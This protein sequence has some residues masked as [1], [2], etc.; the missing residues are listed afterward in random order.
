[1]NRKHFLLFIIVLNDILEI[2]TKHYLPDYEFTTNGNRNHDP[3]QCLMNL[4][5]TKITSGETHSL[6]ESELMGAS[7]LLELYKSSV[8]VLIDLNYFDNSTRDLVKPF[9]YWRNNK[10]HAEIIDFHSA[11]TRQIPMQ[12][13]INMARIFND[14]DKSMSINKI[15]FGDLREKVN[16][17]LFWLSNNLDFFIYLLQLQGAVTNITDINAEFQTQPLRKDR[18]VYIIAETSN[19]LPLIIICQL[20]DIITENSIVDGY[21]TTKTSYVVQSIFSGRKYMTDE[22]YYLGKE[23]IVSDGFYGYQPYLGYNWHD[24]CSP[25]KMYKIAYEF[26]CLPNTKIKMPI[27]DIEKWIYHKSGFDQNISLPGKP[28]PWATYFHGTEEDAYDSQTIKHYQIEIFPKLKQSEILTKANNCPEYPIRP[29]NIKDNVHKFERMYANVTFD[30][31]TGQINDLSKEIQRSEIAL[32][33]SCLLNRTHVIIR[34]K[35]RALIDL[36]KLTIR[37]CLYRIYMG[38]FYGLVDL[39]TW[40]NSKRGIVKPFILIKAYKNCTEVIDPVTFRVLEIPKNSIQRIIYLSHNSYKTIKENNFNMKHLEDKVERDLKFLIEQSQFI[41]QYHLQNKKYLNE[42]KTKDYINIMGHYSSIQKF[43]YLNGGE[44]RENQIVEVEKESFELYGTPESHKQFKTY[45]VRNVKSGKRMK[46]LKSMTTPIG[47][48]HTDLLNYNIT[49]PDK[50]KLDLGFCAIRNTMEASM[51]L[52][53]YHTLINVP[54]SYI[55]RWYYSKSGKRKIVSTVNGEDWFTFEIKYAGLRRDPETEG[56]F[57]LVSYYELIPKRLGDK[58]IDALFSR[59]KTEKM[60]SIRCKN[61]AQG[62]PIK[63]EIKLYENEVNISFEMKIPQSMD[64]EDLITGYLVRSKVIDA[65]ENSSTVIPDKSKQI[66]KDSEAINCEG[67][68]KIETPK[69]KSEKHSDRFGILDNTTSTVLKEIKREI[70]N[71]SKT[72][73]PENVEANSH[74]G[75]V[76]KETKAY[77]P[78]KDVFSDQSFINNAAAFGLTF[79]RTGRAFKFNDFWEQFIRIEGPT[80]NT[81]SFDIFRKGLM[82]CCED[83]EEKLFGKFLTDHKDAGQNCKDMVQESYSSVVKQMESILTARYRQFE[84]VNLNRRKREIITA[85]LVTAG[86]SLAAGFFLGKNND[87]NE[88]RINDLGKEIAKTNQKTKLLEDAMI[89]LSHAN[90]ARFEELDGKIKYLANSTMQAFKNMQKH[91]DETISTI[92]WKLT[93]RSLMMD[94]SNLMFR[95]LDKLRN[96]LTLFLEDFRFWDQVFITLRR[97]LIP[98]ELFDSLTLNSMLESIEEKL[99]GDYVIAMERDDWVLFYNLPFITFIV[100]NEEVDGVMKNFLYLK[101]KIP[102]KRKTKQNQYLIVTPNNLP[103]PCLDNKCSLK[104]ITKNQLIAFKLPQLVWLLNGDSGTIDEEADLTHFSCQRTF[105][106]RLCFTY[107]PELLRTPTLCTKAIYQWNITRILQHCEFEQRHLEDYRV[108]KLNNYQYMLHSFVTDKYYLNCPNTESE[109]KTLSDWAQ[110]ISIRTSCDV[111]V[112]KTGQ[113]LYGPFSKP[114]NG[115]TNLINFSYYSPLIKNLTDKMRN[116]SGKIYEL[117]MITSENKTLQLDDLWKKLEERMNDETISDLTKVSLSISKKLA[118]DLHELGSNFETFTYRSTFWGFFAVIGDFLQVISTLIVIFGTLTYT[119]F[120]GLLGMGLVV[121]RP[122]Q[123]EAISI[124]PKIEILPTFSTHV[125]E[126]VTFISWMSKVILV[127]LFL[128]LLIINITTK[129]FRTAKMSIHYGS[130]NPTTVSQY[131]P[132]FT[133]EIN[134]FNETRFFSY[135]AVENIYIKVPI[136]K[137]PQEDVFD[138]KCKN[139]I[140]TWH[141]IEKNGRKYIVLSDTLHLV[142]INKAGTRVRNRNEPITIPLSKVNW[143]SSPEPAALRIVNNYDLAYINILREPTTNQATN[144]VRPSAPERMEEDSEGYILPGVSTT[145]L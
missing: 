104:N 73:I 107:S 53:C 101:L 141:V 118:N 13:V 58:N 132:K 78:R 69:N 41:R 126:D 50:S 2:K 75:I 138:I 76:F 55:N 143:T 47:L 133:I 95:E 18:F 137:M 145:L 142:A 65:I 44:N 68:T 24:K 83:M 48:E 25:S 36:S 35:L 139:C 127:M 96:L 59:A 113:T 64:Y 111:F 16:K 109:T 115:S 116:L 93:L 61:M 66:E 144:A 102:L 77:K 92:E 26:L 11:T 52:S 70:N 88:E 89:G 40:I 20:I 12:Y 98:R 129:K 57:N 91:Y 67:I 120:F 14:G 32:E 82:Q 7:T 71:L 112:P 29:I 34:G 119:R 135:V 97:G 124:L 130:Y 128:I 56:P 72:L 49:W 99:R 28:N 54:F 8:Y 94:F 3:E 23:K 84:K 21:A 43:V 46:V 37:R 121:I 30:L 80:L 122:Q 79:S 1:M 105:E 17:N 9:L 136:S 51:T 106:E 100:K 5:H 19:D 6:I 123:A 42:T 108:I 114:L 140:L 27:Y 90:N 60:T 103:F 22:I 31:R 39:G 110:V 10:T 125:L 38:T 63:T 15:K 45:Y 81:E 134:I 62:P 131:H 74:Y 87:N 85:M 4:T 117:D 33:S 86:V